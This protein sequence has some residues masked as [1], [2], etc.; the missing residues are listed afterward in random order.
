MKIII[1][2]S[3]S[4]DVVNLIG[5]Q[6][7]YFNKVR[8]MAK[9]LQIFNEENKKNNL[10]PI[11]TYPKTNLF[12]EN[13][14]YGILYRLVGDIRPLHMIKSKNHY[15]KHLES[16]I[17]Y[18][19]EKADDTLECLTFQNIGNYVSK[20]NTW[21]NPDHPSSWKGEI[22]ENNLLFKQK[23][24][25]EILCMPFSSS[26]KELYNFVTN[27][28]IPPKKDITIS[29]RLDLLS[30]I[31]KIED[32]QAVGSFS[33]DES[34]DSQMR[35]E[36]FKVFNKKIKAAKNLAD[37]KLL[38][39]NSSE[40]EKE[41][42]EKEDMEDYMVFV[43]STMYLCFAYICKKFDV[44]ITK[45]SSG[46]IWSSDKFGIIQTENKKWNKGISIRGFTPK[47][48]IGSIS[49]KTKVIN[50]PIDE[51][52]KEKKTKAKVSTG[53]ITIDLDIS[54]DESELLKEMIEEA[55]VGVFRVGK[56]GTAYIKEIQI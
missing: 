17:K 4:W 48:F 12:T 18:F 46:L 32:I 55:N 20:N 3:D 36:I 23:E 41:K 22:I 30:L 15:L 50:Y 37:G 10:E 42:Y 53:I 27:D 31:R 25:Y 1:G 29:T 14:V 6:Q 47:D 35:E 8:P 33:D 56:K 5:D 38:E 21:S 49:S 11:V 52:K 45:E 26:P 13:T 39:N 7:T 40:I 43:W 44:K 51:N 19:I 9:N 34:T 54:N 16:K 28:E 2:Y 24:L